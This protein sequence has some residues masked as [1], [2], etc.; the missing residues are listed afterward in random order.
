MEYRYEDLFQ[1]Q[2]VKARQA[3]FDIKSMRNI[4]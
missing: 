2:H 4:E 1:L 3:H